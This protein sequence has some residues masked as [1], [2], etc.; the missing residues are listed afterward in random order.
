MKLPYRQNSYIPEDKLVSYLLSET[1]PVGRSKAKIFRG[2]GFNET[3]VGK[4]SEALLKIAQTQNVREARKLEYGT[5][6]AI[7]GMLQ[8]NKGRI[9]IRTVWFIELGENQPRFVTAYPV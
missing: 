6:Y 5:N 2:I 7:D 8:I 9:S 3:N 1:H 4:L